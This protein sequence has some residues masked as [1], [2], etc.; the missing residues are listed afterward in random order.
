MGAQGLAI[1]QIATARE[2]AYLNSTNVPLLIGI[3]ISLMYLKQK[4]TSCL[5]FSSPNHPMKLAL[6]NGSPKRNAVSPF[7]EKQKSKSEVTGM[8]GV[9]SCSCCLMRLEP[10]TKPIA[11]L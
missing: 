1:D 4:F 11:H 5:Y 10:P 2:R 6:V 3:S 7:S 9:P 8:A